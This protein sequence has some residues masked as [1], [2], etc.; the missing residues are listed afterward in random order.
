MMVPS[1][2]RIA[3]FVS[4]SG[5]NAER[6]YRHFTNH[7]EAEV[8]A[9]YVNNPEA[10]ALKRFNNTPVPTF[11]F[12]RKD[13]YKSLELLKSLKQKRITHIVLAGFLWLIPDY[14]LRAFPNR[15][16]NIHPSLLPKYGGKG[17]YGMKV[18]E[19]VI[20]NKEPESGITIHLINEVY[21]EGEVL[22]QKSVELAETDTPETLAKKVQKLEHHFYPLVIER[23]IAFMEKRKS[24]AELQKHLERI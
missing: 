19:K 17:M 16:I 15:I 2:S 20:E 24:I 12:N 22:C 5:T 21:D 3:I 23:W 9:V 10:Y 18:H 1:K 11:I 8:M 14:L 13:M 7:P 4:G 6:V